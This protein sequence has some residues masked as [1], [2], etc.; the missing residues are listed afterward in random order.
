MTT[1]KRS[2]L[3]LPLLFLL[4]GCPSDGGGG[5]VQGL[6]SFVLQAYAKASNTDAQDNFGSNIAVDG[7]T[8]VVGAPDESSDA[9]G[10][11]GNQTDNSA[12][13]AGAIYVFTRSGS[14]WTQQ[15]YIKASNTGTGDRFGT[16]VGISGDTIV[17]GAPGEASD[18]SAPSINSAASAG[19]VYVFTRSGGTWTQQAYIKASVVDAGDRFGTAVSISGNTIVVGAV[20][21]DSNIAGNQADNNAADSGAVYIFT[22]SGAAWAQQAYI[23]ASNIG[24]GDQFGST[25]SLDLDTLAVGSPFERSNA[26]GVGGNENDNSAA[27]AGSVYVFIR[28]ANA[29]SQQAYIKASNTDAGDRFGHSVSVSGDTLA[30]GAHKENGNGIGINPGAGAQADNS[31]GASGAVYVFVRSASV[32]TQQSYVKASNTGVGD[33]FGSHVTVDG[34]T[35]TVGAPLEDSNAIGSGGDQTNNSA[36]N[37]GAVYVFNRVGTTW[38]QQAYLKA[39]N[40]DAG[41]LFGSTIGLSSNVIAVGSPSEDSSATGVGGNQA[42]NNASGSGAAYVY[43]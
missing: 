19:A 26:T 20:G 9:L 6:F 21:E 8:L 22:R 18:G 27:N 1:P 23:K 38:T 11:S 42:D 25:V 17:V 33:E 12:P 7:D 5:P 30:V 24:A 15:A 29:W 13:N 28:S 2:W 32:W 4:T 40:T 35:L 43:Q 10:I 39:P 16:S 14:V 36:T 34:N 31:L 3:A 41:D 37:S